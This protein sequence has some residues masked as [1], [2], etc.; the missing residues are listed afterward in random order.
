MNAIERQAARKREQGATNERTV[1]AVLDDAGDRGLPGRELAA[2]AGLPQR[3]TNAVVARLADRGLVRREGKRRVYITAAGRSERG[4]GVPGL[5]L[6]PTLDVALS[7]FPAEALK[8]F[9]RLL[10]SAVVARWHLADEYDDGWPGFIAWGPTKTG[11]TSVAKLVCR[12]YRL[13]ERRAIRV[14]QKETARGI[15]GR[16]VRDSSSATG[17]RVERALPLDLPLL[18]LDELDKAPPDVK[19]ACGALLLGTTVAEVEGELVETKPTVY[20]TLNSRAGLRD[21]H[22]AHIR[23]SVTLDTTLL[24]PLLADLDLEMRRLF[25]GE[26]QIPRLNLKTLRPPLTRLPENLWRLLRDE[27]RAGL[28]EEGWAV[29]DVEAISR[30]VLGRAAITGGTLEQAT[31]ATAYDYLACSATL[32]H[33]RDGW[34][35]RLA[36]RLGAGALIPDAAA[37]QQQ[38]QRV[39]ASSRRRELERASVRSELVRDRAAFAQVLSGS[40][41]S[42]ELRRLPMSGASPAAQADAK[43]LDAQLG[44]L[45]NRVKQAPTIEALALLTEQARDP[46]DRASVLLQGAEGEQRRKEDLRARLS[47][48]RAIG[49]VPAEHRPRA[50]QLRRE[51]SQLLTELPACFGTALT[52]LEARAQ[53]PLT[54]A[55]GLPAEIERRRAE[56]EREAAADSAYNRERQQA[57]SRQEHAAGSAVRRVRV[58]IAQLE[59]LA[60]RTSGNPVKTL[61]DL[62]ILGDN[63]I[64]YFEPLEPSTSIVDR[65][66]GGLARGG[67]MICTGAWRSPWDESMRFPG[68]EQSARELSRWQAPGVQ[69]VLSAAI[70]TLRAY[71]AQLRGELEIAQRVNPW[72]Y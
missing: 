36:P 23:R 72:G 35:A 25:G 51:L 56:H 11:K 45:S 22:E 5:A 29:T 9:A 14:V 16:R 44:E 33:V 66:L 69:R 28:T 26:V 54:A 42:L 34:A 61:A 64:V 15:L 62:R 2:R 48:A 68:D 47:A 37:A 46:L 59:K 24:Q 31:L 1:L 21:L 19:A 7:Y 30:I 18:T 6:V 52:D 55:A 27:L 57:A 65:V 20:A 60:N 13:D 17:F 41:R 67:G 4:A 38:E 63:P 10:F 8:A 12:V 39:A 58:D 49:N 53:A 3:T 50:D 32:E 43:G 40:R 70:E 71:E